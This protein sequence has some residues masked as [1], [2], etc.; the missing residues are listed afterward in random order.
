MVIGA[1][2]EVLFGLSAPPTGRVR[3]RL[4]SGHERGAVVLGF[5]R[6]LGLAVARLDAPAPRLVPP[7]VEVE[8]RLPDDCWLVGLTHD[9]AGEPTSHAGQ[10]SKTLGS[11]LVRVEV[12]G[13][14]GSP[15]FAASGGL[16]GV[17]VNRGRRRVSVRPM[18][19]LVPFLERV[20]IGS[21]P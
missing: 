7:K 1:E 5:D 9:R 16:V 19:S 20:V 2:G 10:V 17:A 14:A 3:V 4:P 12:P 21:K 18:S 8:A 11:G 13:R 6:D 15:I